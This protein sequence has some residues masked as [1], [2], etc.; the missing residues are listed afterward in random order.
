MPRPQQPPHNVAAHPAEAYDRDL[1]IRLLLKPGRCGQCRF[2]PGNPKREG[3][4]KEGKRL[5]F[6]NSATAK[7]PRREKEAKKLFPT[8]SRRVATCVPLRRHLQM[9]KSFFG[10]FSLRGA[11]AVAL[12]KKRTASYHLPSSLRMRRI[13]R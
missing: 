2:P 3:K 9:D 7:A 11:F 4:R 13:Q 5:L 12:F 1:H 8:W 6:L 10:S